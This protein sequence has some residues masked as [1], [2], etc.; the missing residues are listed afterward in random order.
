MDFE[1]AVM[2]PEV[3]DLNTLLKI[4]LR[5]VDLGEVNTIDCAGQEKLRAAAVAL[6]APV[7]SSPGTRTLF[8]GYAILLELWLLIDWLA[9]PEGEGPLE[10]WQP[11]R[12]LLSLA[13][14]QGGYLAPLMKGDIRKVVK[15]CP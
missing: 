7:L 14:G 2:A 10:Q 5:P 1:F 13:D 12:R 9:H 4:A 15:T 3:L 6:A 11:Y 8:L